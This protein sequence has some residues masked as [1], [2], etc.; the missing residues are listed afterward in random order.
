MS[1]SVRDF[2]KSYISTND[3]SAAQF[4]IVASDTSNDLAIVKAAAAT[5]PIVGV[6]QSKPKAGAAAVVRHIGTTKV[7]CGGTITRGDKVTSD[8]NG[9]AVTTTTSGNQVVGRALQSGVSGD[10]IEILLMI[11]TL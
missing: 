3:L 4:L 10:V 7:V 9:K 2:E 5:D 8:G 1:Q 11:H 6:L